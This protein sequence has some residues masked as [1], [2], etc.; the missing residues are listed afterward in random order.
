MTS[1]PGARFHAALEASRPIHEVFSAAGYSLYL[2]G[3]IVRDELA[4]RERAS[5]DYDL[6]TDARPDTIKELLGPTTDALWSQGEKFGTIG[7]KLGGDDFEITTHRAD[8]YDGSSRKPV[9]A[10]G[11]NVHDDL[12]RR[13]FT[14]NAMAV[15][16]ADGVLVDPFGGAADLAAGVLRTPLAPDVS[17]SD[18]PLRMLRAARFVAAFGLEPVAP[19]AAAVTAMGSRM[20]IVSVERVRDELTKLLLLPDPSAGFEFLTRTGLLEYVLPGVVGADVD[21]G[22]AASR[23][24]RV[25]TDRAPRWAALL[26]D[27]TPADRLAE[28]ARLKPSGELSAAV[29]W[30]GTAAGW[31]AADVPSDR[32][33][34]RR[35]AAAAPADAPLDDLL[36]FLAVVRDPDHGNADLAAVRAVLAELRAAEPDLDS[37]E[38]PIDG[39][40]VAAVLGIEPGPPVGEAVAY[41]REQRFDQGPFDAAT[42][43]RLLRERI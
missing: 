18:D 9:V 27:L 3:G 8:E 23:A 30:L 37:P 29:A 1:A 17:F 33:S 26:L 10:F 28:L 2:V 15:D 16:C 41:L 6:T 36:D 12:A 35:A 19:L 40:A 34:L 24:A 39:V 31:L 7:V 20:E 42:A 25:A 32:P 21:V 14:V 22:A 5:S 11:D 38:L 4:G 13:D 43:E